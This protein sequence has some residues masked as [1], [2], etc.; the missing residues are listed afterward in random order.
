MFFL[1]EFAEQASSGSFMAMRMAWVVGITEVVLVR[2]VAGRMVLPTQTKAQSTFACLSKFLSCYSCSGTLWLC[3]FHVCLVEFTI[4]CGFDR[5]HCDLETPHK[6][7][8]RAAHNEAS[9]YAVNFSQISS[10]ALVANKRM[11]RAAMAISVAM[12]L[13]GF[14]RPIWLEVKSAAEFH[15]DL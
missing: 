10:A 3:L 14:V 11:N 15:A 8:Q 4:L 13:D 1:P 6:C 9:W 5:T 7:S 12:A 2:V